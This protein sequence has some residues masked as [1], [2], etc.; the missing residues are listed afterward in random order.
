[1]NTYKYK[2]WIHTIIRHDDIQL[3]EYLYHYHNL[4]I[5]TLI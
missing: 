2:T 3:S 5:H 4:G 1:M